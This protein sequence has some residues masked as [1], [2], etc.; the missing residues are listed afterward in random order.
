M[1]LPDVRSSDRKLLHVPPRWWSAAWDSISKNRT[2]ERCS[3]PS[4]SSFSSSNASWKTASA[5]EGR[6]RSVRW[7]ASETKPTLVFLDVPTL[8]SFPHNLV[9]IPWMDKIHRPSVKPGVGPF[10]QPCSHPCIEHAMHLRGPGTKLRSIKIRKE[11]E[12]ES[13]HEMHFLSLSALLLAPRSIHPS[14][15]RSMVPDVSECL[16][17]IDPN[18]SIVRSNDAKLVAFEPM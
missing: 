5:S 3:F 1:H 11:D 15:V 17:W 8:H 10:P 2:F 9:S 4:R 18:S 14:F 13:Y 12:F 7:C 16:S 6:F